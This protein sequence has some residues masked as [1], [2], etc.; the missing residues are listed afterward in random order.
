MQEKKLDENKDL[1]EYIAKNCEMGKSA[2]KQLFPV[3]QNE[4]FKR[5]IE[6]QYREYD[7]IYDL[8][9]KAL[10]A[11]GEDVAGVNPAAKF[12]SYMMIRMNAGKA[13]SDEEMAKL[14]FKG[15]S[16]GIA[17]ITKHLNHLPAAQ[18]ET[19]DLAGRLLAFEQ[20]N[21]EELKPYL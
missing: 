3:I 13:A 18:Q 19:R 8:A 1:L 5:L 21:I 2:I 6:S 15:S 20:R 12:S 11:R 16:T 17:E 10:K 7:E 9:A 4:M 14:M